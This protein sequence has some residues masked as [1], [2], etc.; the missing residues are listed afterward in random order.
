MSY[1]RIPPTENNM[2]TG[3]GD[4][5]YPARSPSPMEH[6]I[7]QYNQNPFGPSQERLTPAPQ[8]YHTPSDQLDNFQPHLV[9]SRRPSD[10]FGGHAQQSLDGDVHIY[11]GRLQTE[12]QQSYEPDYYDQQPQDPQGYELDDRRPMLETHSSQGFE[13]PYQDQ[14]QA[15]PGGGIKRWKTVKAVTL[16]NGN[17]ILDCPVPPVLLQQLPHGERDEFTHMRYTA[18]TCDP[19]DFKREN[20]ALRQVLFG[21]TRKTELFIVVTMYNEDE[22]LFARTMIGVFKN[23]EYMCN[24]PNSKT[25]GKDAWKNI[26]VCVVS[27]GRAKINPRTKALLSGMGVY[28]EGIAKQQVNGKDVTA[29]IYEY[30]TQTH[31]QLKN[32]VVS[33]VHRRQ[34]VQM[35]FCL[36]EKNQK[37]I[38]SHR[39]FFNAFG[40]VLEPNICVLLDAGTRPG[41]NSIYHLW[42]AFDLEPMC[43]GACGEIKA[44][45]GRGGKNLINPLVATQNFEYKMSNILD[46]PL[47]SAFG[48]ISVLPGAFSAYRYVALQN[49]D[50][51]KGPLEKYFLGETLHG[52]TSAG[53]FESNMYLAEDR[54]LCFEIVTKRKCHW[55]L[56]YVKS[57]TG[58][59]DVPD[60]V[61]ELVLQRRRWLNGS[62]FAAIYAIAHFH[63]FFRSDHSILRKMAFF[64]EFVF[65]TINMVFAW[66]AI[67]NFFLVF[68]ILTTSL[69][70]DDLL[71]K[72]GMI[73]GVVFTWLYGVFLVTC[74]VLA[75]GNRPAGSGKLFTAMVWFW[76]GIMIYLMFAAIFI[77]VKA[78]IKDLHSGTH[79]TVGEVFKNPVFYTLIISVMSTY[80]IWL[81]ASIIMFDPWHMI[82]SFIQYLLLTPTYTNV[83]NVYAF[84]NTHDVSWGT[85]GDDKAEKLPSVNTSKGAAETEMPD[86]G[87]LNAQYQRDVA[88]FSTKHQEVKAPLTP[89]QL[90]EKQMDYYRGVRT[91]VVLI[92]MITNFA[93]AAVVLSTGGLERIT[94]GGSDPAKQ[95]AERSNIY[96]AIVLWSVAGLS[97]F[98]FLGAMWFLVVRM[99]RG[100]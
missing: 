27:D 23:I 17:L 88:L 59:T 60:T 48:F 83:L 80:G 22:V 64:V 85:K 63:E 32:D 74:F 72:T 7:Q 73:L 10:G 92:W 28:Q 2:P 40:P 69:G 84:C 9:E 58:E 57:A 96:M 26:M 76:A 6:P 98:K 99:F 67:G 62:F 68:K 19:S 53:L 16:Y 65:N 51:G 36:K 46:K 15:T 45:L 82:T 79:F 78:V 14:R 1:G 12:Y 8:R 4:P 70:S 93:L 34:P 95:A 42:K 52:G 86:S 87:D 90:Q 29:H 89:S 44:M 56:Q 43:G 30:T 75:M 100:V 33:L 35:L 39:W 3:Y 54:I 55:I 97:S 24:R 21:K 11:P 77:A 47:E 20:Y 81:I 50:R 94:P 41:N 5:R 18:A 71:G 37:K 13:E 31:L 66:F 91:G 38:N 49:D 25:W 61:T